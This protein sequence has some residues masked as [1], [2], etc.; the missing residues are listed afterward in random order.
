[1]KPRRAEAMVKQ[2]IISFLL[3]IVATLCYYIP[4]MMASSKG[5]DLKSVSDQ[6][7]NHHIW[8]TSGSF[9]LTAIYAGC[10][11]IAVPEKYLI[12]KIISCHLFLMETLSFVSHAVNMFYLKNGFSLNQ[13]ISALLVFTISCSFF[14]HRAL[15]RPKSDKFDPN[16]TYIIN[17]LPKN[18]LG[19]LSW[20]VSH[21]GHKG[22]YQA[23]RIYKFSE[24]TGK[25]K[26]LIFYSGLLQEN[27]IFKE[28]P[29]IKNPE[30]LVG[31]EYHLFHYNCNT[32]VKDALRN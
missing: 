11:F 31:N 1:M 15:T 6:F 8:R 5:I 21:S 9:A 28:T 24:K 7:Y 12:V 17:Y 22:I 2:I 10:F 20:I 32:M 4:T 29:T 16:K 26:K 14:I 13:I 25:V 18:I 3:I 23:G 19:V 27:I 30:R